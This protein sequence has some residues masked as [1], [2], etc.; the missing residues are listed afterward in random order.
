MALNVANKYAKLVKKYNKILNNDDISIIVEFIVNGYIRDEY[1]A[2]I[3]KLILYHVCKYYGEIS[4]SN[5]LNDKDWFQFITLISKEFRNKKNKL[6]KIFDSIKDGLTVRSFHSKCDDK[7]PT[8]CLFKN[9]KNFIFGGYTSVSWSSHYSVNGYC[10]DKN[11][12]IFQIKPQLFIAR[13]K[14]DD[15]Q[16]AIYNY[17]GFGP[18]FGINGDLWMNDT[19]KDIYEHNLSSTIETYDC[20]ASL[21]SK[22]QNKHRVTCHVT[23][24]EVYSVNFK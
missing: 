19:N 13:I 9:A 2:Y 16:H 12:F 18:V 4:P 20:P 8:I 1:K 11:A 17:S 6:N 10:D 5:I 23:S 24:Y 3:P 22:N 7:G 14:D 15:T 21:V